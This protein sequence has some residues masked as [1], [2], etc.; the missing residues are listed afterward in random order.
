MCVGGSGSMKN[1]HLYRLETTAAQ[2]AY[3]AP[4]SINEDEAS[5]LGR[6]AN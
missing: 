3:K 5:C 2:P 4:H 6:D 1:L